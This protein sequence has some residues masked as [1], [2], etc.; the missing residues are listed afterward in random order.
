MYKSALRKVYLERRKNLSRSQYWV[1]TDDLLA[2]I[3]TINWQKFKTVHLFLPISAHKEIDTFSILEYFKKSE[4]HLQ[5]VVPRSNFEKLEIENILFDPEYTILGRN[6]YD[7]PE[8]IFGKVISPQQ[9]DAVFVPL[10]AFDQRGNRVG[11]GKGFYDRFL[12]EC[13]PDVEKIGLSFFDPVDEI[14]DI[15]EFDIPLN[16]CVTPDK[17]WEF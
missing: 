3:S 15:N 17:I 9:I 2:Q 14:L 5:V 10:L 16:A 13:R 11:Y 12:A 4:P 8:P 1:L 7:I 6:K